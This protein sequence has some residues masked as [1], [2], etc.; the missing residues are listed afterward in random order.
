M[1]AGAAV[2]YAR[3]LCSAAQAVKGRSGGGARQLSAV[4]SA[5]AEAARQ[6]V[7]ASAAARVAGGTAAQSSASSSSAG[8]SSTESASSFFEKPGGAAAASAS[9]NA[10][11]ALPPIVS[12]ILKSLGWAAA[13]FAGA[14]GYV[15]YAYQLNELQ[16]K[17]KDFE[18]EGRVQA[19]GQLPLWRSA[20]LDVGNRYLDARD[21]VE[22]HIKGFAEPS[23]DK[24]LPDLPP[25][26][27]HLRTLVLDLDETLI[28]SDWQRERGWRTFKRPGVD[29]FLERMAHFFEIVVYTDSLNSYA[30]PMIERLDPQRY[31]AFRLFRDATL[32]MNNEHYKDISKLNRDPKKVLV[33]TTKPQSVLQAENVIT[34]KPYKLQTGDTALLDM[35]PFLEA[36]ARQQPLD[37]RDIVASYEGVEDVAAA[38]KERTKEARRRLQEKAA[39]RPVSLLRRPVA[40]GTEAGARH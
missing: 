23:S 9:E 29:A 5:A 37:I 35:M 15:S 32:Y 16:G 7:E 26:L 2:R 13:G 3:L 34:V 27:G 8:G 38:Y 40:A 25:G 31:I 24:L 20:V 6:E 22:K 19:A 10:S 33:L 14:V 30:D 18:A 21:A 4:S 28:Y 39:Q 17:L 11:H 36:I 1:Q 12:L